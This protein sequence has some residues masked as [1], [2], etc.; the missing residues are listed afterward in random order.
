MRLDVNPPTAPAKPQRITSVSSAEPRAT[1]Q[2]M[3]ICLG[4]EYVACAA[5]RMEET[6]LIAGFQLP[7]E[8][9]YENLDGV[10]CCKGIV[11]PHLFEQALA[12]HDDA[13][14]AHEVL[15]QLELTLRELDLALLAP[16]LVRVGVELEVADDERRAPVRRP[17]AQER[18]QAREQLL[19]LE[20]LDEVVVG[21]R[22][23]ALD[24]RL[25]CVARREHEDRDVALLAQVASD[26]DA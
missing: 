5:D 22:V 2:R 26:V 1:R 3:V 14:V 17:A 11:A 9:R 10:R 18:A 16:H 23:E 21:A 20:G 8:I 19:A 6:R 15:E 12:R 25:D 13:F 4:A 24:A 7:S